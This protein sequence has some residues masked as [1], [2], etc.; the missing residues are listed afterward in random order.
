[1][2]KVISIFT[3][4]SIIFVF[5]FIAF[6]V[7]EPTLM[8]LADELIT[9][10]SSTDEN[11]T[12]VYTYTNIDS[13]IDSVRENLSEKTDREIAEF[14]MMYTGQPYEN[15]MDENLLFVL[16]LDNIS[17]STSYLTSDSEITDQRYQTIQP[18][19]VWSSNDGKMQITTN[20]SLKHTDSNGKHYL[21]W[22]TANWI[23]F[24]ITRMTDTFVL[25]SSGVFDD[26]YAEYASYTQSFYCDDCAKTTTRVRIVSKDDPSEDTAELKYATYVPYLEFNPIV[27]RCLACNR[28]ATDVSL[29]AFVQYQT[30]V[31]SPI[32]IQAGYAHKYVGIGSVGISI[33]KK[34]FSFSASPT[35]YYTDYTARA[36]TL[37]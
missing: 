29:S 13:F 8:S 25:Y 32:N 12:T 2:K 31:G 30:I 3:V 36:L 19:D 22:S 37:S 16:D 34:G 23:D 10:T 35:V 18:R 33:G 7:N 28:L 26:A 9:T 20:S 5:A 4:L 14:I 17:T 21:I 24:P 6:A 27:A 1:M 15:L 11:G